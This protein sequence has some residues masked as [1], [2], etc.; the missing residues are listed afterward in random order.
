MTL[1]PHDISLRARAEYNEM[2]G[3][4]LTLPQASRLFNLEP[5]LCAGVLESLVDAGFLQRSGPVYARSDTGRC[6]A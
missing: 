5:Q 3:L 2:P 4:R 1:L 6:C